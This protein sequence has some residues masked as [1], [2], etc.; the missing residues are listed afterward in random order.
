MITS[1]SLFEEPA[2]EGPSDKES[3]PTGRENYLPGT[4]VSNTNFQYRIKKIDWISVWQDDTITVE[5]NYHNDLL[6]KVEAAIDSVTHL[7]TYS[8]DTV[9]CGPSFSVFNDGKLFSK[10]DIASH[11]LVVDYYSW[12]GFKLVKIE[13]V[14]RVY[15]L[16]YNPDGYLVGINGS[17][18]DYSIDYSY[19]YFDNRALKRIIFNEYYGEYE[20]YKEYVYSYND[21]GLVHQIYIMGDNNR[22]W[23]VYSFGYDD[24]ERLES[25]KIKLGQNIF[26]YRYHY[27]SGK[28]NAL[29][30]YHPRYQS[31]SSF[32]YYIGSII[33]NIPAML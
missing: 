8:N 31:L 10:S 2:P 29:Y 4:H 9:Y 28:G 14:D 27:E 33:Y 1:C 17:G 5:Y 3:I 18:I 25:L 26:E 22:L 21:I 6:I 19:E 15:T 7:C 24:L 12:D 11:N 30:L 16:N 20:Q 32:D 23:R 13:R